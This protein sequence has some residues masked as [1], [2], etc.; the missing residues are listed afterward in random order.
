LDEAQMK[1]KDKPGDAMEVENPPAGPSTTPEDPPAP[2]VDI[3]PPT[4]AN[5]GGIS[6]L[7][8]LPEDSEIDE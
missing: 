8:E 5:Q 2:P 7:P 3:P 4:N 1:A 6:E